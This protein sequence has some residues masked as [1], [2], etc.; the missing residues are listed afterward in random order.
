MSRAQ[1]RLYLNGAVFILIAM[2]IG[3]Y[4]GFRLA[5]H[6]V[7]VDI[8]RQEIRQSHLIL[9]ATGLWLIAT[10]AT[11][12]TLEPGKRLISILVW[13]LIVSGYTFLP[14]VAI[15]TAIILLD[16]NPDP[17]VPQ[18]IIL[19]RASYHLG[20]IYQVSIGIS[21]LASAVGGIAMIE[22]TRRALRRLRLTQGVIAL[23][24]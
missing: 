23:L 21:A 17:A 22:A 19:S 18:W 16:A 12:P 2:L 9:V 4:P 6:N 3:T 24:H 5:T 14:A 1:L 7:S 15:H 10:G 20:A 8:L 11:L 13:A